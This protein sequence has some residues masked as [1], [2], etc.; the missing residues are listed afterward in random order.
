ML[1]EIL[2]LDLSLV[3]HASVYHAYNPCIK[4]Y[5]YTVLV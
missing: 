5:M 1:K 2:I 4:M 3:E